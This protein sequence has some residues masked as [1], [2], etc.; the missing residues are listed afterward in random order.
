MA[1]QL[2]TTFQN[3]STEST[4]ELIFLQAGIIGLFIYT[5]L[6]QLIRLLHYYR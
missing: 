3:L 5:G 6:T 1:P 2:I 4:I